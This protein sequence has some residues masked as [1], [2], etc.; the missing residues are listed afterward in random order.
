MFHVTHYLFY[1]LLLTWIGLHVVVVAVAEIPRWW[2]LAGFLGATPGPLAFLALGQRYTNRAGASRR[3]LAALPLSLVGVGIAWRMTRAVLAGVVEAGGQFARTPKFRLE[4]P[5]R[6][7]RDRTYDRPLEHTVPEALLAG[8]CLLGAGVAISTGAPR[9][10]GSLL[11]FAA[12]FGL[13]VSY[14]RWQR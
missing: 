6:A 1:P 7:W 4:G 12:A 2:L 3:L 5:R 11:F 8:W 13:V 9:M 14:A 10:A